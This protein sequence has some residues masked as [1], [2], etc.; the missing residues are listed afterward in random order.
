MDRETKQVLAAI[1]AAVLLL[2]AAVAVVKGTTTVPKGDVAVTSWF[3]Q[4]DDGVLS[5]GLHF[6][7]PLKGVALWNVQ[8]QKNEEPA[9]VPTQGGLPVQLKATMLYHLDPLQ[10]PRLAREVGESDFESRVIDPVFKNVVRDVCAEFSPEA[11]YT[12][13]RNKVEAQVFAAAQKDLASRGVV[14]EAVMLLDPVLPP[15]V[16]ERITAKVGAEQDAIR[17]QSVFKSREQ[18]AMA[19]LRRKELES[20]AKVVEAKGIAEAQLI[21][22]KDLDENYIRYLWV[23]ALSHHPGAVIYV[24]TGSDGLPILKHVVTPP[25]AK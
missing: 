4:V 11:L 25:A 24:P 8:T 9:T 1:A 6:V 12:V 17:M 20:Q 19:D 14:V 22:K 16:A 2:V 7:N 5:P 10:V 18:E 15:V 23:Q 13:E 3:G 21:I